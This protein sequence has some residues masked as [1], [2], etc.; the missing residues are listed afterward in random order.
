MNQYVEFALAARQEGK[1]REALPLLFEANAID[2]DDADVL[3]HIGILL[4]DIGCFEPALYFLETASIKRKGWS[5]PILD[6][7]AIH[8]S[9]GNWRKAV[10]CC[11]AAMEADPSYA[12]PLLH[13]ANLLSNM[14]E[15]EAASKRYD[16]A[17][18]ID[19]LN[20]QVWSDFF[21]SMNYTEVDV[22]ERIRNIQ[23]FRSAFG[24]YFPDKE[25]PVTPKEKINIGYVS[26]DLRNHA[27][28]YF[29]KGIVPFHDRERFNVFFYH[30]SPL[31]DEITEKIASGGTM[32]QCHAMTDE[33]LHE[34]IKSDGI[35]ILVDLNGHTT[36][37]RLMV[38]MMRSAPIQMS[39]LG[40]AGTTAC[41]NMDYKIIAA[42]TSSNT[43]PELY[44]ERILAVDGI[45]AYDPP[46]Y[47]IDVTELPMKKNGF[48]TYACFNNPRKITQETLDAWASILELNRDSR[49]M[50][51][52]KGSQE[53]D[54]E[55][56][57]ALRQEGTGR[58]TF[59]NEMATEDFIREMSKA[60]VALDPFPHGGGTTAA[61]ALWMGVPTITIKG[62]TELQ[63]SSLIM[64]INGMKRFVSSSVEEY[65]QKAAGITIDDLDRKRMPDEKA[66][67]NAT[68]KLEE[69]YAMLIHAQEA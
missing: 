56:E 38:F 59:I 61:H 11:D 49:L 10:E 33:E 29:L 20:I 63:L 34:R 25:L 30:N 64:E 21:L 65:I 66:V 39:W 22:A 6:M 50:I 14:G 13:S 47:D 3:Y 35:D 5:I 1:H 8:A 48:V 55:M 37:N 41:P 16:R 23:R 68:K 67:N 52:T 57:R 44:T 36:G 54:E 42:G 69:V 19:P 46:E 27:M 4:A 15:H 40:F 2:K 51:L 24:S 62:E 43:N 12:M 45:V 32:V 7:G 53:K 60:D 58:V 26:S 17:L 31:K 9:L 28:S 18:E